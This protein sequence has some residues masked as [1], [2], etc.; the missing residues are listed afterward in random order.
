MEHCESI[1]HL[2]QNRLADG[3]M[4]CPPPS[5]ILNTFE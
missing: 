5:K 2:L 3:G 1:A 4:L